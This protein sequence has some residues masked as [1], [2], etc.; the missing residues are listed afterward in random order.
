MYVHLCCN[1]WLH[2]GDG[3]GRPGPKPV[4]VVM[5]TFQIPVED[6]KLAIE[7]AKACPPCGAKV[8]PLQATIGQTQLAIPEK[9]Q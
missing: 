4:A 7:A 6:R 3:P 9:G 1:C 2:A 8:H 5:D